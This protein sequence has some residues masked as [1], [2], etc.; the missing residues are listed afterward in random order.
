MDDLEKKIYKILLE[1]IEEY[2]IPEGNTTEVACDQL[3]SL[4]KDYALSLPKETEIIKGLAKHKK[5]YW[6]DVEGH[7]VCVKCY[8]LKI[9]D[10]AIK[11]AK[12]KLNV[13]NKTI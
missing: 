2:H 4:M 12:G 7:R 3:L 10:K 6:L 9:V 8:A 5:H 11:E 13:N 1:L